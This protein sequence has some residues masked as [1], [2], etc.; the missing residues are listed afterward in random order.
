MAS[1]SGVGTR[2]AALLPL[3]ALLALSALLPLC[4]CRTAA[5]E[6]PPPAVSPAQPAAEPVA[7]AAEQEPLPVKQVEVEIVVAAWAV[8]PRI[9]PGGGSTQILVR[10]QRRG[11]TPLAGVEVRLATSAGRLGSEGRVLE[12]DARGMARDRLTTRRTATVTL[13]A[14][15]TRYRF[16]VLVDP[17]PE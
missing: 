3:P 17:R 8:P 11:G 5:P 2:R 12:T 15:G 14:G 13:N 1:G 16:P 4:A 9:G 10:V 7:P 6:A